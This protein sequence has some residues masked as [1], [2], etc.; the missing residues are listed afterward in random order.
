VPAVG[1]GRGVR[2]HKR[3]WWRVLAGVVVAAAL[4][5]VVF[6]LVRSI[7]L[8]TVVEVRPVGVFAS[9]RVRLAWPHQGEAA[10][11]VERL[12]LIGSRG[13]GR[14]T[15]IAS[16]AKVMTAYV[17]L[18]DHPLHDGASGPQITVSAGD[19]AVYRSDL[20]SG[21]SVV[22][23]ESGERLSERQALQGMLLASGNNIATLLARWDAGSERRFVAKMNQRARALGLAH[24]RYTDASGVDVG[25]VSTATDQVRLGMR[26]MELSAFRKTVGLVR[27]TLPVAGVQ[28]N[29]DLLLGTDGIVG[30]KPGT[31]SRAGGCFLFAAR[32]RIG[33]R[34]AT[35]VGA[36]L[37]H[38]A[39]QPL[40]RMIESAFGA[41]TSLLRSTRHVL[42]ERVVI[43]RRATVGWIS[44][45]WAGHVAVIAGG[46][47]A[48]VG[49]PALRVRTTVLLSRHLAAPIHAGQ[50]VGAAVVAAG[51]QRNAVRLLASGPLP[52]VSLAWRLTHP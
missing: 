15:P 45:P 2:P 8:R 6:A 47:V 30:I 21:Q 17:I 13:S 5:Y 23:V 50:D 52:A 41:T 16:I 10:V 39:G 27:V 33:G 29:K 12:G 35:L 49:W 20:R 19:V 3:V 7:P 18:R 31:T 51:Q 26:A 38:S 36:V 28:Y 9:G 11:A 37:H 40:A 46:S 42:A 1:G 22:G 48:L 34:L 25:T 44:V 43:R 14:P 24:T 32:E 4:A